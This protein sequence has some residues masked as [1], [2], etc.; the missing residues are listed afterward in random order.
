MDGIHRVG[1]LLF[2]KIVQHIQGLVLPVLKRVAIGDHHRILR[3]PK[4]ITRR[5]RTFATGRGVG[6][7]GLD[8]L[9]GKDVWIEIGIDLRNQVSKFLA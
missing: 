2:Q 4:T 9:A 5:A 8:H 7:E 1:Q 3:R 6:P